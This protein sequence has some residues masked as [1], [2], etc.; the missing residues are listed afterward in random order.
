MRA[1]VEPGNAPPQPLDESVAGGNVLPDQIGDLVFVARR[2]FQLCG[3]V[4]NL[5]VE[6]VETCYRPVGT[7]LSGFLFH[8][9]NLAIFV[10]LD[11]AEAFGIANTV[12]K[13]GG[14]AVA[15]R[16]IAQQC[17]QSRTMK[18]IVA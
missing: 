8:A 7:R 13:Y 15:F 17:R 1:G 18:N 9:A 5:L 3:A 2:F 6:E 4:A 16:R 10:E 14:A 11:H 12:G